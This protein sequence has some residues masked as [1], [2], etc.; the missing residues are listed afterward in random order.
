MPEAARRVGAPGDDASA[1]AQPGASTQAR[2]SAK[3]DR[4]ALRAA[5][6]RVFPGVMV[7]MFLAAVDQTILA[8][9]LPAIAGSLGGLADVSWVV[10]AYLLATTVVAPLY[11]HLG[12]RFGRRRMLVA[13]V[14][15][16]TLASGACALAPTLGMLVA[17]RALQGMGGGGLMTLSQA[18]ISENVPPRERAHFQGYFAAMFGLSST[19]GPVLGALLTQWF[20]WRAVFVINL[21]LGLLAAWLASRV[22]ASAPEPGQRFHADVAGTVLFATGMLC[23]LFGL[24][25][26]GHRFGFTDWRLYALLV[27]AVAC[28]ALLLRLERK[29]S[30]P[31]IPV[32]LLAQPVILRSNLVV[33]SFGASLFAAVL[34][35]PLYLQLGRGLAIGASGL[36]LL[37]LTLSIALSASVTGRRIAR[38]G[39]LTRYPRRGL[40]IAT[41]A[42][43]ALGATVSIAPTWLVIALTVLCGVGLGSIMPSIQIIVQEAG[44]REALGRAVASMAVSRAVGGALGVAVVGALLASFLAHRDRALAEV[45][46]RIAES[47]GAL[48][49]TLPA[50]DRAGLTSVVDLA[51]RVVF[52]L[53]AAVTAL[54]TV[55]ASRIPKQLL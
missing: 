40:A 38:T 23:L 24:S 51:F 49:A 35:L 15:L 2:W 46:P 33:M 47:G 13:A 26:A 16:F 29:R 43:L 12:D 18:L 9:A 48:L 6:R 22:P 54:G 1:P 10:V 4:A 19:A 25:S 52:W 31:V 28:L 55:A 39:D 21:P 30:D 17:A 7:A 20:S 14:G 36:L 3:P 34:Y 42:F 11:G 27:F 41:V 50:S 53:V 37:P 5:F 8:T 44:G 32:R 45:L